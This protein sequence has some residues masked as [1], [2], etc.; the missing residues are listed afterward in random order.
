MEVLENIQLIRKSKKIRREDMAKQLGIE[1]SSYSKTE[2]GEV[3]LSV[4]RLYEIAKIFKMEV[5]D[6]LNYQKTGRGNITYLPVNVQAG[7]LSEIATPTYSSDNITVS[8]PMFKEENLYMVN[9]EGDSMY[10][11]FSSGDFVIIKKVDNLRFL[12]FGEPFIFDTTDGRVV[13]RVYK[14]DNDDGVFVM[15][16]D[17]EM[18][19]SYLLDKNTILS[20]WQ[21]KGYISKNLTPKNFLQ[22]RLQVLEN[23]LVDLNRYLNK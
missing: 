7:T 10:P 21:I 23:N 17:N 5:V 9:I 4:E 16:S 11:T 22:K 19:E 15:K 2:R 3:K 14:D 18:Y 13:K 12:R 1:L 6:I 8:I 20:I